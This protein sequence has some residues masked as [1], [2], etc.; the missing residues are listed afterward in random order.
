MS[1]TPV[2]FEQVNGFSNQ[3]WG[4]GAEDDDMGRRV[5]ANNFSIARYKNEIARYV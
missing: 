3:Y 5:R 1:L 2:Q 4:W